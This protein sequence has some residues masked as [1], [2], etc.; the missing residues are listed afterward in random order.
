MKVLSVL[1]PKYVHNTSNIQNDYVKRIEQDDNSIYPVFGERK[2]NLTLGTLLWNNYR[3]QKAK[4]Y[5]VDLVLFLDTYS[6]TTL[7]Y[8]RTFQYYFGDICSLE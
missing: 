2:V 1:R 8:E 4:A 6:S 7:L 5:D 3:S